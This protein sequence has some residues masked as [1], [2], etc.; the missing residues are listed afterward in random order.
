MTTAQILANEG[1][2]LEEASGLHGVIASRVNGFIFIYLQQ[3]PIGNVLES[4]T[5]YNF[6]DNLPKRA[7]DVSFVTLEKMPVPLDEELNFAPDLTVEV[8]SKNDK[9]YEIEAKIQHYQQAG[10][11]LIWI[12]YPV[13]RKVEV[14]HRESGLIEQV[15]SVA[16]EL[17]GEDLLPGFKLAVSKI[18]K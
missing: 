17:D 5:T 9:T 7:P 1:E 15:F 18:F 11:R 16:Q 8:V 13:S 6:N 3:N 2:E 10:V 12:I 14:Y 4:S